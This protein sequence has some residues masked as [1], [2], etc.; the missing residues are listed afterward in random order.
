MGKTTFTGRFA[1]TLKAIALG[2]RA[3]WQRSDAILAEWNPP[4]HRDSLRKEDYDCKA[5]KNGKHDGDDCC[6]YQAQLQAGFPPVAYNTARQ[7]RRVAEVWPANERIDGVTY[8]A[9]KE[10]IANGGTTRGAVN[11]IKAVLQSAEVD[12]DPAKVTVNRVRAIARSTNGTKTA[13]KPGGFTMAAIVAALQAVRVNEHL[14]PLGDK[15]LSQYVTTLEAALGQAAKHQA[16]RK[17]RGSGK[18]AKA[19]TASKPASKAGSKG[20]QA[21]PASTR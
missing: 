1:N 6:L 7:W 18:Q 2:D 5:A 14:L 15:E 9:H 17:S 13:S 11:A 4:K 19:K 3:Q 12:G 21:K 20:K 10:A 16:T 8:S